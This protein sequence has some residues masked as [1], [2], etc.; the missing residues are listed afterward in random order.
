MKPREHDSKGLID[1]QMEHKVQ[2]ELL[3]T[4]KEFFSE[5]K[6]GTMAERLACMNCGSFL[7]SEQG[8]LVS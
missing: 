4:I 7:A 1:S 5:G 6:E 3:S 8:M 2:G